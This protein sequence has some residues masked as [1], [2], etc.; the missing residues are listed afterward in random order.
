MGLLELLGGF[1]SCWGFLELLG[2]VVIVVVEGRFAGRVAWRVED[3]VAERV[4]ERVTE[5]CRGR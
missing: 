1:W 4:A 2:V 3:R 5:G